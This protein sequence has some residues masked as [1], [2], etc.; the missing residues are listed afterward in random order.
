MAAAALPLLA[1]AGF[2][3][4]ATSSAG[5]A[6]AKLKQAAQQIA[7]YT[8]YPK[9]IN[10]TIPLKRTPTKGKTLIS[11]VSNEPGGGAYYPAL[12]TATKAAGWT[13][14][15][16]TY[17]N[18][19]A[20]SIAQAYATALQQ[21]PTAVTLAGFPQSDIGTTNMK[22]YQAAH[23]PIILASG[24]G[25]TFKPNTVVMDTSGGTPTN[26][27]AGQLVA[28]E[29]AVNSKGKGSAVYVN[30]P[31]YPILVAQQNAFTK[32]LKKVCPKCKA[33]ILS[34]T[35]TEVNGGQATST[36]VSALKS[37]PTAKYLI[38]SDAPI[39]DG[40]AQA[41][42]AASLTNIKVL[43]AGM[44]KTAASQL[45]LGRAFAWTPYA[46]AVTA[47]GV[48]DLALRYSEGMP[49]NNNNNLLPMQVLT[50]KNIGTVTT[51][52]FPADSL[53][54]YEKLWKVPVTSNTG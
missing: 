5:A 53:Q 16:V 1:A 21:H 40:W 27:L 13:Y 19:D 7:K 12:E 11:L 6:T 10:Q 4:V 20:A 47:Q 18:T 25:S 26:L 17:T 32:Q 49:T 30:L 23:V 29:L 15:T 8:P 46:Q 9:K 24:S 50:P 52:Q 43:G 42:K 38:I 41:L 33:N 51:W 2:G 45:Q 36:I 3:T 22:A 35:L 44:D 31:A 54:Q 48:V 39:A 37:H 14:K 34:L 28:D